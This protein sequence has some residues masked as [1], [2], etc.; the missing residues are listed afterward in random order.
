[1]VSSITKLEVLGYDKL[2]NEEN[3]FF[4]HFFNKII[5]IPINNSII[6]QA[7]K[8]R[9]KQKMSLGDNLI[10]ASSIVYKQELLTYNTSDF[11]NINGLDLIDTTNI[12]P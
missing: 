5:I 2:S 7:I 8:L 9:Q 10:A 11:K 12:L 1:M 6:E 3:N 4:T